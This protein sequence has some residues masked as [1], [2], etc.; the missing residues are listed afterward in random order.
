M[1]VFVKLFA[2]KNLGDDLFLKILLERYPDV[3][4]ILVADKSYQTIFRDYKNLKVEHL[5]NVNKK[6][7]FYVKGYNKI[8]GFIFKEIRKRK[9]QKKIQ[10]DYN[11]MF[12]E[13]DIFVSIGG[14]I[15]MQPKRLS[16]YYNF[17]FYK[18]VIEKFNDIFFLGCNFG[19]YLDKSFRDTY[20]QIFAKSTDVCFRDSY[21]AELFSELSNIRQQPDIVFNLKHNKTS[22][23]KDTVGFSIISARDGIDEGL[24]FQKYAEL[25][26]FY[27]NKGKSVTLFSFCAEQGDEDSIEAII[28]RIQSKS[29]NIQKVYYRGDMDTFLKSYSKMEKMYSGRFHSM[30]LSMLFNQKFCPVVYNHK[31]SNVLSD[32]D[33]E[34]DFVHMKDFYN[35]SVYDM[36]KMLENNQYDIQELVEKSGGQFKE[37]DKCIEKN[38]N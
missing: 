7:Y 4:F 19:P 2:A 27:L 5:K 12:S 32:S 8:E 13:A 3:E 38:Y 37:L 11:R 1:K 33:F 35:T 36:D 9:I 25:I 24:Y 29:P 30:I 22:L 6:K 16:V 18:Y 34:G 28:S 26:E 20:A 21:S 23:E 14:S 15:F 10:Q 31:M 17:E